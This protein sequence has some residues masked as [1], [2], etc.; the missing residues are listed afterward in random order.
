MRRHSEVS[1]LTIDSLPRAEALSPSIHKFDDDPSTG[2]GSSRGKSRDELVL[3]GLS[4]E[5]ASDIEFTDLNTS[6]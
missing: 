6:P 4:A 1:P 3:S 2:S 5:G